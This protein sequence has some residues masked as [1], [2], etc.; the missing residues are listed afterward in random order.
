M[1]TDLLPARRPVDDAAVTRCA[2]AA[3][4]G[5]PGAVEEFVR[6]THR[7]VWRFL[8]YLTDAQSADDLTQETYLRVWTALPRFTG[9]ASARTWLMSIARR[10]AVDRYRAAA[11]RPRTVDHP[12]WEGALDRGQD[13]G[14]PGFDEGVALVDLCRALRPERREAFALTQLAGLE[15]GEAARVIGC[16][17]G[18]VRSRVAR[19]RGDLVVLLRAADEQPGEEGPVAVERE[20]AGR[21]AGA[22]V[23]AA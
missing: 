20:R 7:D 13:V 12:D 6:A 23:R 3:G 22:G 4:A 19:A 18:T 16:P 14:V 17:V 11:S 15:Y 10:V 1:T 2:L 5:L 9:A 8:A 21:G